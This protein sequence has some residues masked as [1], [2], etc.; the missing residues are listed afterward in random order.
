MRIKLILFREQIIL[1]ESAPYDFFVG[2]FRLW[3]SPEGDQE[4]HGRTLIHG[5]RA[6]SGSRRWTKPWWIVIL[7]TGKAAKVMLRNQTIR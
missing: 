6:V 3:S 2:K 1:W 5:Q 4:G 7:R